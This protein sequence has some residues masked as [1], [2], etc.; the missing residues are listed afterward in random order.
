MVNPIGV[1][2]IDGPTGS[3]NVR[4]SPSVASKPVGTLT[5]GVLVPVFTRSGEGDL[6]LGITPGGEMW[7]AEFVDGVHYANYYPFQS[8]TPVQ[9]P[10]NVTAEMKRIA[11]QVQAG[12]YTPTPL[13]T[14]AGGGV[15]G[16]IKEHAIL[17]GSLAVMAGLLVFQP[18]K[19]KR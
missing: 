8:A 3:N 19:K 7:T 9:A 12:T 2:Q 18:W 5:K 15:L 11:A 10:P 17:T 1:A 13:A 16:W 4:P 6:W 14:T